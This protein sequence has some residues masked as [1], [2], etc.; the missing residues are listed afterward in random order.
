VIPITI[1]LAL[2]GWHDSFYW[3]LEAAGESAYRG[4]K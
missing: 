2:V 1:M 4:G 3:Q